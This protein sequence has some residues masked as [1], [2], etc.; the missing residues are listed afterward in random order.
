MSLLVWLGFVPLW[1]L[2]LWGLRHPTQFHA[3]NMGQMGGMSERLKL[4]TS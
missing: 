4:L 3:W 1:L 2:S